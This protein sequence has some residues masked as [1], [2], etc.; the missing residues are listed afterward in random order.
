MGVLPGASFGGS[1]EFSHGNGRLQSR[2][3]EATAVGADAFELP[4]VEGLVGGTAVFGN[5]IAI[6]VEQLE[7]LQGFYHRRPAGLQ[8]AQIRLAGELKAR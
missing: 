5:A 7:V 1:K 8:K 3:P 6:F 2:Q 4:V